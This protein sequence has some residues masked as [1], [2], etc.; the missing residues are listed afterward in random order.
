MLEAELEDAKVVAAQKTIEAS[1]ILDKFEEVQDTVKEADIIINELVIANKA[2]KHSAHDSKVKENEWISERDILMKEVQSLRLSNNLKDQNYMELEQQCD[3]DIVIMKK[4]L[5][6][7]EDVISD[8]QSTSMGEWM[9]VASEFHSLKFHLHES[10]ELIKKSL[11]EVWSEIIV[12]DCAVSVL[13][14]CN[15][16][17]LLETANGLNAENGLLH[18]GICESNSIISNLRE[19]NLRSRKELEMCRLLKGKLLA[20]IKRGFNRISSKVD[21]VGDVSL[22]LTVFEKKILDLQYQ[23]EVMLQRSNDMGSELAML[24]KQ[25]DLSNNLALESILDQEKLLKEKDELFRYQEE[26]LMVD[27]TAKDFELLILS[28][29]LK[30]TCLLKADL[31]SRCI[32]TLEVLEKVKEDIVF[33]SIDA[34]STELILLDEE[35][36]QEILVEGLKMKESALETYSSNIS[37][38]QN[39]ICLLEAE[40]RRLQIELETKDKELERIR[41]L[42]KENETLQLHLNTCKAEYNVLLQELE[43]KRSE[44]ES[45]IRLRDNVSEFE[46]C[47]ANL[48]EELSLAREEIK[49]LKLSQSVVKDDLC[50]IIPELENQL[51]HVKVLK[52]EI[53]VLKDELRLKDTNESEYLNSMNLKMMRNVDL[54]ENIGQVSCNMQ[55]LIEEK[56]IEVDDRFQKIVNE[57]KKA[58]KFLEQFEFVGNLAMQLDSE[59]LSI[60]VELSRKDDILNGLL[61]DLSL[62]QESASN[63]KDQKDEMEELLSSF[64]SLEK[65]FE[66]KSLELDKAVA[67]GQIL[68]AQLQEKIAKVSALELDLAND[69]ETINTLSNKNAELLAGAQDALDTRNSVEKELL[70]TRTKLENLETEVAEMELALAQMNKTTESLKRNLETVTCQR[71]ELESKVLNFTKD[72]EMARALAEENEGIAIEAQEVILSLCLSL[73]PFSYG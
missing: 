42:E 43:D 9:S 64:R 58:D 4:M 70:E 48:E 50:L 20:D 23:E 10:T 2:L 39:D 55:N 63:S 45:S 31:E 47:T 15:M 14:L 44:L 27:L 28:N 22:K 65:D 67:E 60:Q 33:K 73:P 54:A 59:I 41:C 29:E 40:T 19:H 6:E 5:L 35:S 57:M 3:S 7:L 52:E 36:R 32:S 16:G 13:H 8:I 53:V 62:L 68:E 38:L 11:E 49:N 66:S 26:N 56:F 12:K 71:D 24:M 21:E 25:I 37:E 61:F 51:E 69:N 46:K 1:C 18:H 34:A 30:Q 72:L 17:I